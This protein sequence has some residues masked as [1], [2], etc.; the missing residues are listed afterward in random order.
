MVRTSSFP[1]Q[2]FLLVMIPI[3]SPKVNIFRFYRKLLPFALRDL[4]TAAVRTSQEPLH[5]DAHLVGF[6]SGCSVPGNA[7]VLGPVTRF[8]VN[9]RALPGRLDFLTPWHTRNPETPPAP[10]SLS[11][12]AGPAACGET[13]IAGPDSE[14][15]DRG[16][17]GRGRH[18]V[19][20]NRPD[21]A[22]KSQGNLF[23]SGG[24]NGGQDTV[25]ESISPFY[26][27]L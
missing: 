5:V 11:G 3:R 22:T 16:A 19:R 4:L 23:F 14:P 26:E 20:A 7:I 9:P 24:H 12:T 27:M 21:T 6:Q 15:L 17:L 25:W 10:I 13:G 2:L 18:S 8:P 1:L